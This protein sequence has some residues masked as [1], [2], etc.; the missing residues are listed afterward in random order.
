MW[1]LY[2]FWILTTYQINV[3]NL[4][5]FSPI[6]YFF[7]LLMVPFAV[8]IFPR[9]PNPKHVCHDECQGAYHQCFLLGAL[10]FQVLHS[11]LCS[12]SSHLVSF[13]GIWLSSSQ[14]IIC[15][16]ECPFPNVYSW[17]L[18]YVTD[19]IC[20]SL[21]LFVSISVLFY[22][23]VCMSSCNVIVLSGNM[24]LIALFFFLNI[25]LPM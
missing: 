15:W 16:R 13:F 25:T 7:I 3:Y 23:A 22:W 6:Q 11:S 24:I 4:Q 10:W 14:R 20:T 8:F 5:V 1:V 12:V 9:V 19:P 18:C 17:L 2:I 21:F